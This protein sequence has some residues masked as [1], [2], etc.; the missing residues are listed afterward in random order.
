MSKIVAYL[1][2]LGLIGCQQHPTAKQLVKD[3]ALT[4]VRSTSGEVTSIYK[5][6]NLYSN[7]SDT[8]NHLKLMK[9]AL[10]QDF[11]YG[12][13]YLK[14]SWQIRNDSL[15]LL[16]T[17]IDPVKKGVHVSIDYKIVSLNDSSLVLQRSDN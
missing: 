11:I 10:F 15:C 16:Y 3:W 6:R 5:L 2:V 17:N 13:L 7:T 12:T 8:V 4:E 1:L 9:S 14:G